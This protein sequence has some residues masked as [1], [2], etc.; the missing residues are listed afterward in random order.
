VLDAS[1]VFDSLKVV[2]D[3]SFGAKFKGLFG[4]SKE[5]EGA[6]EDAGEVEKEEVEAAGAGRNE[7]GGGEKKGEEKVEERLVKLKVEIKQGDVARMS[8]MG[9]KES[10]SR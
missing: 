3:A 5:K 7:T 2:E 6:Q 9:K 1:A 10:R 8:P 4:G